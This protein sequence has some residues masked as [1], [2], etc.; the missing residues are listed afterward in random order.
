M[1]SDPAQLEHD[2]R[3]NID[4]LHEQSDG[5]MLV[6]SSGV[7]R[8]HG[9]EW[10]FVRGSALVATSPITLGQYMTFYPGEWALM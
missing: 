9:Y 1:T 2:I 3:V 4:L 7:H 5:V 10:I 6:T 8:K